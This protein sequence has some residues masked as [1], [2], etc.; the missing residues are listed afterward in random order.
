MGPSRRRIVL[1]ADAPNA[2]VEVCGISLLERLLRTLQRLGFRDATILSRTPESIAARLAEP[3]WARAEL[4]LTIQS[5]G[6]GALTPR[7]VLA[8]CFP[9][10]DDAGSLLIIPAD[11][12]CDGRLLSALSKQK[13]PALLIDSAPPV[14][15]RPLLEGAARDRQIWRCGPVFISRGWLSAGEM[16]APLLDWKNLAL[17]DAAKQPSYLTE[18]RREIRPLW[19]PAPAPPH[20]RLAE[21]LVLDAA[22]NGTLDL[23]AI[24]HAPIETWIISHLCKMPVSPTQIT[25]FTALISASVTLLFLTG[26]LWAGALLALTVGVLDGLDGKQ[27]R[28]KVETTE[29]GKWEHNLDFLL[30]L[31]WW[32][33]LAYHLSTARQQPHAFGLLALLVGSDLLDRLAKKLVKGRAGRHLDDVSPIDRRVRLIGGRR[34]IYVWILAGGLALGAVEKAFVVLCWWGGATAAIHGLRAAWILRR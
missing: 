29:L 24:V 32:T 20:R 18:M 25:L 22:Q 30:E 5:R 14:F 6:S 17:L 10:G 13:A 11:M 9:T 15:L 16:D 2:L 7:Q 12:Y 33:A 31:S 19:F 27:A 34:N 21:R 1:L 8:T 26:N 23:P 4:S 3:S 28:V